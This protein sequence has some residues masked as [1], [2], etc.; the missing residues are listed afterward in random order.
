MIVLISFVLVVAKEDQ[1]GADQDQQYLHGQPFLSKHNYGFT[2]TKTNRVSLKTA[3][4][5]MIFN[6]L[7]PQPYE[8]NMDAQI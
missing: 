1:V 3:K 8:I 4:A 5:R 2:L 7:I 6:F